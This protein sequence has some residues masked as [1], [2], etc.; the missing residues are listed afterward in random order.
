[1]NKGRKQP[2]LRW[3]QDTTRKLIHIPTIKREHETDLGTR[4]RQELRKAS[5]NEEITSGVTVET[6]TSR[7]GKTLGSQIGCPKAAGGG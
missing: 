1:M 3:I 4:P 2:K 7:K 5:R 6:L